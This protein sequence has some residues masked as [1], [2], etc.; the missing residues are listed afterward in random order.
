MNSLCQA[1]E[2]LLEKK[3]G[4]EFRRIRRWI[5]KRHIIHYR[6]EQVVLWGAMLSWGSSGLGWAW[7]L[8]FGFSASIIYSI[9]LDKLLPLQT[10]SS[11]KTK[12]QQQKVEPDPTKIP[13]T[14]SFLRVK[15]KVFQKKNKCSSRN[16]ESG[17]PWLDLGKC[18]KGCSHVLVCVECPGC[19][20]IWRWR[21][22]ERHSC[23]RK[24]MIPLLLLKTGGGGSR[25]GGEMKKKEEQSKMTTIIIISA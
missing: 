23:Q 19:G 20:W 4:W 25:E 22:S 3:T 10:Y 15:S 24:Q 13:S 18:W 6:E 7:A 5:G 16:E 17:S 8:G 1:L 2:K 14:S 11:V 12:Q 21:M 9:H